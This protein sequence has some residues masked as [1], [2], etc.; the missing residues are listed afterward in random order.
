M[1]TVI[2]TNLASLFAQNSLSSAQGNLATSVQRLSSGLRI[3]SAKD[4][5]AGLA[6][7][8]NMQGQINGVN[9]SIRNLSDATNLL[10][11]A[12]SSLSTVQDMLLRMKQLAVKG[13]NG[14]LNPTQ[15]DALVSEMSN[16]ND[17]INATAQ[18]T[19]FTGVS[20]LASGTGVDSVTAGISSGK[21]LTTTQPT[22]T[23][24]LAI[25][26]AAGLSAAGFLSVSGSLNTTNTLGNSV[27]MTYVTSISKDPVTRSLYG[28]Y[29]LTASDGVLTLSHT[30][31][32]N[33]QI[34]QQSINIEPAN[35]ESNSVPT[36]NP[37]V[38][39]F[40]KFGITLSLNTSVLGQSGTADSATIANMLNGKHIYVNS[41]SSQITDIDVSTTPAGAYQFSKVD[42][43]LSGS[44]LKMTWIDSSNNTQ[45]ESIDL[46]GSGF[47]W[48]AGTN[49]K[50]QFHNGVKIDIHNF[51]DETGK[52]IADKIAGLT[53]TQGQNA[54]KLN[55]VGS[56]NAS[57]AFQSGAESSAFI[58]INTINVQTG[59]GGVSGG[60][61]KQ[62]TDLGTA[63]NSSNG[64]IGM[65]ENQSDLSVWQAQF[66]KTAALI[67]TALD[68]ISTQR[69][70]YGAQMYRLGFISSN[71]TSAST[72]LQ[73]SRSAIMDTD[74]AAETAKLTKGQIMQQ[75]ATA[76]LA[77]ANQMPNVILS[78]LK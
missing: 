47:D 40:D 57:L 62:M 78:L 15:K 65:S 8:Q 28:D 45:T 23:N 64:L 11:T 41:K 77:Q 35:Y 34:E 5:A 76:M 53:D 9:Q 14:A 58:N 10:Q 18:R 44:T 73:N 1:T 20:L 52:I 29:K 27:S 55:I 75:A 51:Q 24:N 2:N 33:S 21:Y 3:N 13:Y 39:N 30:N 71:L 66:K 54:G 42:G 72:N 67:D 74:F 60:N 38:V 31:G 36:Q 6:I 56:N 22:I 43:V 17:E 63:I 12:D 26:S 48:K 70:V 7:A 46:A 32:N 25:L 4:D 69:S 19:T 50:I 37:Q 16:L 49:T 59:T 68:W 61:A